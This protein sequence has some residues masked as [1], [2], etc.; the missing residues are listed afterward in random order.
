MNTA[1]L[2]LLIGALILAQVGAALMMGLYRRQLDLRAPRSRGRNGAAQRQPAPR[3][4]RRQAAPQTGTDPTAPGP[5]TGAWSG[6]RDFVVQRRIV[7]DANGAVCSFYLAPADGHPLPSYAPGQYLTFKLQVPDPTG[8]PPRDVVRCYSLSDR[9]HPERYRI[10]VKRVP[11]PPTRPD[12]PAGVGSNHLHDRIVEGAR[13][14]VR[15]P[16]G[17]FHLVDQGRLPIVLIAGGIGITPML[18]ILNTLALRSDPREVWLFYGVRNGAEHIMKGHLEGLREVHPNLHLNVCYSQPNTQDGLGR[19]YQHE[20]QIDLQL[21]RWNLPFGRYEFYLCGPPAMTEALVPAL[22]KQGVAEQNIHY[23]SFGP[24]S[25]TRRRVSAT[26]SSD[27]DADSGAGSGSTSTDSA[28]SVR[29][30]RSGKSVV[31]DPRAGSLL[32][33]AEDQGIPIESGCRAGSCGCC[34]TA[35][36]SGEVVYLQ[37]PDADIEPGHCLPCICRPASDL[38]LTL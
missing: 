10:T 7:E 17:H 28:F 26:A 16:S 34:Q 29:F 18:S 23:E 24:A 19:D 20:G 11:A 6:Y 4:D 36:E 3:V 33:L 25:L 37:T 1:S 22:E 9:P 8:G 30:T 32:T 13:L 14:S 27:A 38:T 35:V 31:W 15:A 12:L 21:L 2:A 5:A